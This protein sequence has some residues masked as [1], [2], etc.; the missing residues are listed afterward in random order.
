MKNY[1]TKELLT[2]IPQKAIKHAYVTDAEGFNASWDYHITKDGRHFIPCCAEGTFPGFVRLYEYFPKTNTLELKF[3]LEDKIV[4]YPRTIRPSKFHTCMNDLP[5]GKIIM[6]THTTAAAPTHHC[7]MPE[8]YYTHMW[9]GFM[10]S[11]VLIYDPKTNEVEDLGIPVP[12]ESIYGA[13]YIPEHNCLFFITYYRG[14]AYRFNLDDRSL[15]D[16]GQITEFG[17]YYITFGPDGNL[18]F[19]SRSGD[20]WRYNIKTM[21]PE[22]TG[23]EVPRLAP[24]GTKLRTVMTYSANGPDGKL[25]FCTHFGTHF[26]SYDPK[27]NTLEKL[28]EASPVGCR[29]F[30]NG[31][32]HSFVFGMEFDDEG[33]LWYTVESNIARTGLHLCRIDIM[34]KGSEPEDFGVIGTTDRVHVVIENIHIRDGVLYLCDANGPYS[35]GVGAIDLKTVLEEKDSPREVTQDPHVYMYGRQARYTELYHGDT[36]LDPDA[37][38]TSDEDYHIVAAEYFKNNQYSFWCDK[39]H[40]VAKLW[41]K[42][43]TNGSQVNFIE[44]GEDGYATA[45]IDADGGIAVKVRDGEIISFEN[46]KAPTSELGAAIEEKFKQ[47]KLPAH[48]GRQFLAKATAYGE[49]SDG[50]TI[51]GTADGMIAL[52]KDEKVFS[53][54]AV[55]NDGP[56]RSIAV[57]PDKK[58]AVGVGGDPD[59]LGFVFTFNIDT[60]LEMKGF[61]YYLNDCD[62]RYVT[63]VSCVPSYVAF[64]K[65]GRR[66]AIGA[67]DNLG[68]VYE[69][70]I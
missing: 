11:N 40:Y 39:K 26:Y 53:L 54:G 4:V 68:C 64:S 70:E 63:G 22:Y 66:L 69:Y 29:H 60:G 36:E 35:P 32:S 33:K 37:L 1:S 59:S 10:G 42:F 30:S 2:L 67:A 18:Y 50:S 61:T 41:K 16:Y 19:S 44:Y 6:T 20:L 21:Q 46:K 43:G 12:R 49:L 23:I 28:A 65:D 56:V 24:A 38:W 47:Y 15:I 25:Y 14:H 8:A 5:D 58:Y 48:P 9:E 7:W 45:Y 52:I 3:K 51:V 17:S 31:Y 13:K 27:T 55:C 34:K 57:S 62:G